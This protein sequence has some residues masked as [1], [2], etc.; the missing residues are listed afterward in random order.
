[1]VFTDRPVAGSDLHVMEPPDRRPSCVPAG[2]RRTDPVGHAAG[3][4]TTPAR[5]RA[6]AAG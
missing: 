2:Y 4:R 1:M 6:G 5:T 3:G